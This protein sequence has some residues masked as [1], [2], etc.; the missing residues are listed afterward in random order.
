MKVETGKPNLFALCGKEQLQILA[1]AI[2]RRSNDI[3][4]EEEEEEEQAY[5]RCAGTKQRND[6]L[7]F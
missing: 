3:D 2:A 7:F 5:N 1:K 4:L 6:I